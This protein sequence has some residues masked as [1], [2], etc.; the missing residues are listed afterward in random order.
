M[1]RKGKAKITVDNEADS[2]IEFSDALQA[3]YNPPFGLVDEREGV[4]YRW[5]SRQELATL[6]IVDQ[7]YLASIGLEKDFN[8][9]LKFHG[10]YRL[11]TKR[12]LVY[13]NFT[14]E[15]LTTLKKELP[16]GCGKHSFRLNGVPYRL[17]D[18]TLA[19]LMGVYNHPEVVSGFE[20]P[21]TKDKAWEQLTG[22][23]EFDSRTASPIHLLDLVLNLVHKFVAHNLLGKTESNKISKTEL[24]ILWCVANHKPVDSIKAIFEG[25]SSQK[26]KKCGS[27]GL[28]HL[29]TNFLDNQFKDLDIRED[30]FHPTLLNSAFL[31][32]STFHSVLNR[33]SS[34]GA[35][36]SG[37]ARKR[38][39]N[40]P[41]LR[42]GEHGEPEEEEATAADDQTEHQGPRTEA[43]FH[44]IN[45]MMAEMRDLNLRTF[46]TVQQ[47]DQRF[48][49]FEQNM[50][51]RLTGLEYVAADYC[52]RYNMQ[53]P[54]PLADQ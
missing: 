47:M 2:D 23:S 5:F 22:L 34:G 3:K 40:L 30:G 12:T 46:N 51:Q 45:T 11:A 50:D 48:T 35:S 21:M 1:G 42:D 41:Q 25:F 38:V 14:V 16:V 28:G 6:I 33:N 7:K 24:L 4:L 49:T 52:E 9:I 19:A 26:S 43:Q 8:E 53:W 20:E 39:R 44:A 15:F 27:I 32:K 54:P 18:T 13:Y 31:G 37:R 29:V 36:S 10:W 17:S